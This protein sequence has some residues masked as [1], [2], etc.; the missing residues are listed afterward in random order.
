MITLESGNTAQ[1]IASFYDY[2]D[3]KKDPQVVKFKLYDNAYKLLHEYTLDESNK[4]STGTYVFYYSASISDIN[5]ILY[6]EFYGEIDGLP[7]LKRG[8]F[9]VKFSNE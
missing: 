4:M 7:T 2:T 6:Y 8:S 5:K 9:Q 1:L 3:T